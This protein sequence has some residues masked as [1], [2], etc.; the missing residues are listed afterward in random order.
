MNTDK[1]DNLAEDLRQK[2]LCFLDVET[3]GSQIGYH[4]I[5]EVAAIRTAPDASRILNTWRKRIRPC[6]PERIS[7]YAKELTGFDP[8]LW[9]EAEI[10]NPP[11]WKQFVNFVHDCV[12]VC[13]NPSFDRAFVSL[14]AGQHGIVDLGLDYHWI[15]TESLA[16]PLYLSGRIK[17]PSLE[18]ICDAFHI[19]VEPLPHTAL[20]GARAC[21]LVYKALVAY[22]TVENLPIDITCLKK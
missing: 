10:S 1:T 2:D 6:Y 19:A 13:H 18:G 5:I 7:A 9:R 22:C 20:D 11:L 17:M 4:E 16:W 8:A 21:L 15:G 14:A 12:P 3:T